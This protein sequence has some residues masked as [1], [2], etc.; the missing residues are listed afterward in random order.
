MKTLGEDYE[1]KDTELGGSNVFKKKKNA[2][3]T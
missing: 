2:L 1:S 3:L